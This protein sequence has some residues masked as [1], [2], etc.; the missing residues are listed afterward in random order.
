MGSR[1]R[2]FL[3]PVEVGGSADSPAVKPRTTHHQSQ[4]QQTNSSIQLFLP[5]VLLRDERPS[6]VLPTYVIGKS[7]YLV[8]LSP[9][10]QKGFRLETLLI[11]E[12][13]RYLG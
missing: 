6:G 5:R 7:L 2:A 3:Q 8:L 1:R 11:A 12:R 9:A 10:R 13:S 4:N